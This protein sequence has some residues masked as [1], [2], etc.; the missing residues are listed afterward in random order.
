[1]SDHFS[2][3]TENVFRFEDTCNVY[4][5]RSGR[6]AVL[7]DFGAGHV[8]G[9]LADIG[10]HEV[11][12]I[13]HTHH[14]RDQAQG[15]P[16]AAARGIPILVPQHERQLFDQ[17]ETYWTTKQLYDVYNVRN[18]YFTLTR[19]VA[20]AGVL[21]DYDAWTGGGIRLEVLPT[22]G[23]TVGSVS[24]VG[25]IDGVTIAFVGDLLFA[26]GKVQTLYDMQYSYGSTDGVET[27]I[28]ALNLLESRS[29]RILCPSHGEVMS[30]AAAAFARTKANLRSFVRLQPGGQLAIDEVDFTPVASRLL[31][32]TQS[33]SSFYVIL[34]RDGSRALF[35][36]YGAPSF[37][38]F[39]PASHRFEPGER[40]RF[41]HHSL[42]PA[43]AVTMGRRSC[44]YGGTGRGITTPTAGG[45]ARERTR[46]PTCTHSWKK[47]M[48]R[49]PPSTCHGGAGTG[50][51]RTSSR[52]F[53]TGRRPG[54]R[55]S[56]SSR[57]TAA[58]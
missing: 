28:L 26:P 6:R 55:I 40:V 49:R 14:H 4:V 50:G 32:A 39:Q 53:L 38:L 45:G 16:L 21:A 18:T 37:P 20:V 7:I 19:S 8:L 3:V 25:A 42:S 47:G 1:M 34:S 52:S 51:S 54:R 30:D 13:L 29:S 17:V 23:H 11:S 44:P 56:T 12:A 46:G 58:A 48:S 36:D 9:H 22:P 41:I 27:A 35:V 10:V 2:R 43:F 15:D 31:H 33:C 57:G 5:L 24:L